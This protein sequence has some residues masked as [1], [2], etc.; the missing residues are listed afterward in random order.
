MSHIRVTTPSGDVVQ[1][2][3]TEGDTLMDCMVLAGVDGLLA[4][5]GGCLSCATC[6][7]YVDDPSGRP[8][9]PMGEDERSMLAQSAHA[10]ENSRLSCQIRFS[11][12]LAGARLTVAPED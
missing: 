2:D 10:Q 5:C 9:P 3:C 7:V 12:G 1:V 8:W 4:L 11:A 6:H